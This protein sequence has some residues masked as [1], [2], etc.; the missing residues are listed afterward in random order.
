MRM[1]FALS[2]AGKL[3]FALAIQS[4]GE[5]SAASGGAVRDHRT[6]PVVRDHLSPVV[7]D[8]RASP[9]VRDHRATPATKKVI[10]A[11]RNYGE[12][13]NRKQVIVNGSACP[14]K[15]V[16]VP[17]AA[18]TATAVVATTCADVR[19]TPVSSHSRWLWP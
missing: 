17:R 10:R 5:A 2:V 16:A 6:H 15:R 3:R 7:R 1:P 19:V 14:A 4:S 11:D 13:P 12:T 8:H 9:V 18:V